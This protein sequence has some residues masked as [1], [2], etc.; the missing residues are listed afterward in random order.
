MGWDWA[1][2]VLMLWASAWG[3]MS[4]RFHAPVL[5]YMRSGCCSMVG[6]LAVILSNVS[7]KFFIV[8]VK[9]YVIRNALLLLSKYLGVKL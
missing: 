4:E 3:G 5:M 1:A 2:K 7:L 9:Q 6:R 8:D